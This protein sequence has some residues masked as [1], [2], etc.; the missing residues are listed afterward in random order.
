M[1]NNKKLIINN[2]KIETELI[3][4]F[5]DDMESYDGIWDMDFEG[6]KRYCIRFYDLEKYHV[7]EERFKKILNN[8]RLSNFDLNGNIYD[9]VDDE[10]GV[11]NIINFKK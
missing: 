7:L 4:W 11:K 9:I 10:F 8:L 5:A 3:K 1:L 6:L 2:T